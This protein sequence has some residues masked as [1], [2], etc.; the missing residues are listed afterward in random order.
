MKKHYS[1]IVNNT[2]PTINNLCGFLNICYEKEKK[3]K[4]ISLI[5]L[6]QFAAIYF[7][8]NNIAF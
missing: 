5:N 8:I 1:S 2:H 4:L 7:A 3:G 6:K